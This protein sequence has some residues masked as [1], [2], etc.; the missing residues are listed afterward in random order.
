MGS[1]VRQGGYV[2]VLQFLHRL[3]PSDLAGYP[4]NIRAFARNVR[5]LLEMGLVDTAD[6][7]WWL[8][9]HL[10]DRPDSLDPNNPND[11][12][13]PNELLMEH[14]PA[15]NG[16]LAD[17]GFGPDGNRLS[18]TSPDPDA[19]VESHL[20]QL[21]RHCCGCCRVPQCND[22]SVI[23]LN[24]SALASARARGQSFASV[25]CTRCVQWTR[26]ATDADDPFFIG[27][28]CLQCALTPFPANT[29]GLP[30]APSRYR[31][32]TVNHPPP[33]ACWKPVLR[34]ESNSVG[35]DY[36]HPWPTLNHV[37]S[38]PRIGFWQIRIVSDDSM[39][40]ECAIGEADRKKTHNPRPRVP[41]FEIDVVNVWGDHYKIQPVS[42]LASHTSLAHAQP[43][44]ISSRQQNDHHISSIA[45]AHADARLLHS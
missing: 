25:R 28:W 40:A 17:A 34:H 1:S 2:C 38:D 6:V 44:S 11:S 21:P 33:P 7:P 30:P 27:P 24:R 8:A 13:N 36:R 15:A 42:S 4:S 29:V 14:R 20:C 3:H 5:S 22:C 45:L 37:L 41:Q 43:C 31:P 9:P 35:D 10:C 32:L 26:V 16:L 18:G 19:A 12:D 23:R 39:P